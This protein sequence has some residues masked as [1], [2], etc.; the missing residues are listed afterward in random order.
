MEWQVAVKMPEALLSENLQRLFSTI[1]KM[2]D[3]DIFPWLAGKAPPSREDRYRASTIVA[4][5]LTPGT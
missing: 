1:T 5:R 2:L 4:D 3:V